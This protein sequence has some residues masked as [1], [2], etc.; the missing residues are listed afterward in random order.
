MN[1]A[2]SLWLWVFARFSLR[3]L[4]RTRRRVALLV[5]GVA[6]G[7]A[8]V[9]GV[10]DAAQRSTRS[11]ERAVGALQ[12]RYTIEIRRHTGT[13]SLAELSP[14][15]R[16]LQTKFDLMAVTR[17]EAVLSQGQRRAAV[18]LLGVG[19]ARGDGHSESLGSKPTSERGSTGEGGSLPKLLLAPMLRRELGGASQVELRRRTGSVLVQLSDADFPVGLSPS[20]AIIDL[21]ALENSGKEGTTALYSVLLAPH[22]RSVERAELEG[23]KETLGPNYSVESSADRRARAEA[24]LGAFRFNVFIMVVMT[25]LV[26]TFSVFNSAQLSVLS[27][28]RDISVLLVL[29]L[30]RVGC[31]LFL[32]AESALIGVAGALLGLSLGQPLSHAI[33][34]LFLRTV[35]TL[36]GGSAAPSV[37]LSWWLYL[38]ALVA[39]VIVC[40]LGTAYPALRAAQL[41]LAMVTR[42]ALVRHPLAVGKLSKLAA[43]AVFAAAALAAS[44][45]QLT[46]PL[47]AHL[48]AFAVIT[49]ALALSPLIL[50]LLVFSL[51]GLIARLGVACTLAIS[52]LRVNAGACA[53]A[54]STAAAGV[55]LLVGVGV[56]VYSFRGTL[57]AWVQYTVRAELFL[58]PVRPGALPEELLEAVS[59]TNGVARVARFASRQCSL[60]GSALP[61]TVSG[62]DLPGSEHER[63]FRLLQGAVVRGGEGTPF[64]LLSESGSRKLN[65]RVGDQLVVCGKPVNISGIYR[66]FSADVPFITIDFPAFAREFLESDAA[67]KGVESASVYL[68]PGVVPESVVRA[69][70]GTFDPLQVELLRNEQLRSSIFTIFDETFGITEVIRVIVFTLCGLGFVVALFQLA[71]E[72][73]SELATLS[74]IGTS[75]AQLRIASLVESTLLSLAAGVTGI[76]GGVALGAVLVYLINPLSFGWTLEWD[77]RARDVLL[78]PALLVVWNG[79]LSAAALARV[80]LVSV[81]GVRDE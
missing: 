53:L 44:G 49:A 76:A 21:A 48:C 64:A 63:E 79:V 18:S 71:H 69:L 50:R 1:S 11:F 38:S 37:G 13:L 62:N 8:V 41:P 46:Q 6:L 80:S 32:L 20:S 42:Q 73:R 10:L 26:S 47:L 59:R 66:E 25:L 24:L 43:A 51:G 5:C 33:A 17:E 27:L 16:R 70:A 52:S 28:T 55:A 40:V 7:V 22:A 12:S 58:K 31:F 60:E 15:L 74:M 57:D 29:G 34:R 23:L 4:Q 68:A 81:E 36:Y 61:I 2:L 65:K 30:S 19:A 54:C 14:W 3:R 67:W 78:P 56:M 77:L 39:G 9:I 45:L 72:R 35:E 75:L